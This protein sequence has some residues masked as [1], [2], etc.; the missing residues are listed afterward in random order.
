MIDFDILWLLA[1]YPES[2]AMVSY[3]IRREQ[4]KEILFRDIWR[5]FC[6]SA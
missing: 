6:V 3:D 5:V 1:I 4:L 2:L